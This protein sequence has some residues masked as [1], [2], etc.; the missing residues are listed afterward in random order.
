MNKSIK[1][2]RQESK[3]R[4]NNHFGD[5]FIIVFVPFFIMNAINII[6]SQITKY[7]PDLIEIYTDF[8]LEMLFNIFATYLA[9][10]LLIQ[11]VRGKDDL[12]FNN[13]FDLDK[14]FY[15][16]VFLRVVVALIFVVLHIPVIPVL[17]EFFQHVSIMVD[18]NA[19]EGYLL[20]SDI[21]PRFFHAIKLSSLFL[22]LFWLITIRLQMVPFI[23]VDKKVNLF[24]AFKLSLKITKG[25]YFKIL[26]FPF[27]YILWL[28]LIFTFI[29][30][31]YVIPLIV[32]GY[33]YLY[34]NMMDYYEAKYE[35]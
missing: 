15:N 28:L 25:S 34:L 27:T 32:V 17:I 12:T 10:K 13:F 35:Y 5:A 33:G 26:V 21:V 3:T 23:I 19:I 30:A 4:V 24:E 14:G 8:A 7:L 16:F 9:F 6:V 22:A 11:H 2:I 31:F 20:H 1:E 18:P 29:G